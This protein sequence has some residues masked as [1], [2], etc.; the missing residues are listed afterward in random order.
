MD[1]DASILAENIIKIG[2]KCIDY[3]VAKVAIPS[4]FVKENIRLS[5]L[6][7]KV[8]DEPRVL[9]SINKFNFI[10]N[11]NI[12]RKHLYE[13]GVDLTFFFQKIS[14]SNFCCSRLCALCDIL[15]EKS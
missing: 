14:I 7:R 15:L 11:D 5:S 8:N 9:C 13:D 10:S 1:I 4:F 12:T 2:N 3:G 6:T